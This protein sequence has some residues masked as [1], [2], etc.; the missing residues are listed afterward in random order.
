VGIEVLTN[1]DETSTNTSIRATETELAGNLDQTAGGALS[2]QT[3]GLVDL[4]QHGVSRLGDE[5]GGETGNETR[6]QIDGGS[7]AGG[8]G[9]LVE[10]LVGELGDLLV[11]DELGHGV[12]NPGSD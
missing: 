12:W 6:S 3:L 7:H 8:D 11:D 5:G 4:A 2:W 1:H 10:L 9:I